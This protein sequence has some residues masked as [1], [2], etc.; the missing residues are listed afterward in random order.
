LCT[1]T[2]GTFCREK[3]TFVPLVPVDNRQR[4]QH[5]RHLRPTIR[6]HLDLQDKRKIA[7][8]HVDSYLRRQ[9]L[10][11]DFLLAF[12]QLHLERLHQTVA[13]FGRTLVDGQ[14]GVGQARVQLVPRVVFAV[15]KRVQWRQKFN[16]SLRSPQNLDPPFLVDATFRSVRTPRVQPA[17]AV[18]EVLRVRLRQTA[19]GSDGID[20]TRVDANFAFSADV[21]VASQRDLTAAVVASCQN[22]AQFARKPATK[23]QQL[24]FLPSKQITCEECCGTSA[25]LNSA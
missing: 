13:I 23:R 9:R 14:S 18:L 24:S 20:A 7:A 8:R 15:E 19:R 25:A 10:Q 4:H 6:R 16:I 1:Q 12:G 3:L 21:H 11:H 2:I 22:F 5:Q 17:Q